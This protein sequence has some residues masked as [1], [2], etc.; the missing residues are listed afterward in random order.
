MQQPF[1]IID[2]PAL[3]RERISAC[4]LAGGTPILPHK[5]RAAR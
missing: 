2:A 5:I 4:K 3:I 1:S